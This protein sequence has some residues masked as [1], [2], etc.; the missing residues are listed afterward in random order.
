MDYALSLMTFTPMVAAAVLALGLRGDGPIEQRNAKWVALLATVATF[1]I[2]LFI[3]FGFDPQ[4]TGFQFVEESE[5][6]LGCLLY[7]SPSP[8]DS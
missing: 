5:W 8:R 4:D 7:T 1:V 2:S 3:F 6:L